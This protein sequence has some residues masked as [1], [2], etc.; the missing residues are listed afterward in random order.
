MQ[1]MRR[2]RVVSLCAMLSIGVAACSSGPSLG[3]LSGK[4]AASALQLALRNARA[5]ATV[6]F[7][8][9]TKGA[10][11][12][13]SVGVAGPTAGE[14]VITNSGGVDRILVTG[15]SGYIESDAPG[16][17]ATMGL[18]AASAQANANRWI[19]VS[20]ADSTF[21][22]LAESVSFASTLD[23][24]TP[25][26]TLSMAVTTIDGH[27]VGMIEGT[28]TAAEAVQSYDVEM[29][30]TTTTPV[31]PIAGAVRIS[32]NGKTVTQTAVFGQ[33]GAPVTVKPPTGAV[34]LSEI[35]PK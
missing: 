21:P 15:D 18:T 20:S 12:Q 14:T 23:E 27:T 9:Q 29:A 22:Q 7:S 25:G 19:A 35:R 33:W 3:A 1:P 5:A 13:D 4:S 26:G 8:I 24:F 2:L 11:Q 30:V 17:V 32:A 10:V 16:L 34:Q 28:G 31:L 6:H